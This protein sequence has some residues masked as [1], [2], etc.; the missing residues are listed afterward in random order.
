MAPAAPNLSLSVGARML[1]R[2]KVA[3][4]T[5]SGRGIG[6]GIASRFAREGARVVVNDKD[7]DVVARTAKEIREAGGTC[8]EVTGDVSV[9]SEVT[10]LFDSTLKAFGTLDILV[11]NAQMFVNQGESGAFL[12]M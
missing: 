6:R 5:G 4:I 2:N 1:L 10:R 11:N 3:V 7:A 12:T 8:L 9:E